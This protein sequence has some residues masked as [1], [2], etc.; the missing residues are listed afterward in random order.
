MGDVCQEALCQAVLLFPGISYDCWLIGIGWCGSG[1]KIQTCYRSD[2]IFSQ[3]WLGVMQPD[4]I[5]TIAL[6]K[7]SPL[8][9]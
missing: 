5:G 8:T 7:T 6:R 2:R 9:L 3:A 4:T 1:I